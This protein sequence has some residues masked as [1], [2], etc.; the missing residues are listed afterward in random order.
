MKFA[1]DENPD[2]L[3]Q[4]LQQGTA[5]PLILQKWLARAEEPAGSAAI[6][7][8]VIELRSLAASIESV[9]LIN[10]ITVRR[11]PNRSDSYI[12]VTGER[13]WWAHNLLRAE[14]RPVG[15]HDYPDQI[16]VSVV[17]DKHV[18]AV[19]IIENLHRAD[20]TVV[21]T[22]YGLRALKESMSRAG[23]DAVTWKQIEELLGIS[24]WMRTRII[25]TLDLCPQALRLVA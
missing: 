25:K 5:T 13:R 6:R 12:V 1:A 11:D 4:A 10:P 8:A 22:A 23:G 2:D 15:G 18:R 3:A 20:L 7:Q 16:Q 19:Q 24:R 21:E 9:G 14:N 17:P